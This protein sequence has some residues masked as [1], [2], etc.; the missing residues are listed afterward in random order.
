MA[1]E[2]KEWIVERSGGIRSMQIAWRYAFSV[3]EQAGG[4]NETILGIACEIERPAS[5][6]KLC[7]STAMLGGDRKRSVLSMIETY[8]ND[9]VYSTSEWIRAS[10]SLLQFLIRENRSSAFEVQMGFLACSGEF[11]S[12]SQSPYSF[13][14]GVS[15]FLAEYGFDG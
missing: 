5:L 14:E 6:V 13:P 11:L 15:K 10:E 7:E 8:A 1:T 3:A 2:L 4:S 9:S 12:S